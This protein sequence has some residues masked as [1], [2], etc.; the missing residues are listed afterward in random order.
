MDKRK[1][2]EITLSCLFDYWW[3]YY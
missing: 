3:R 2:L 1:N